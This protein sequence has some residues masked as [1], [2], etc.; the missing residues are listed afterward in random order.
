MGAAREKDAPLDCMDEKRARRGR[1]VQV[2]EW[3]NAPSGQPPQ[4]RAFIA[5]AITQVADRQGIKY[6]IWRIVRSFASR[7]H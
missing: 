2:R 6:R 1:A 4:L 3:S 5:S 7:A